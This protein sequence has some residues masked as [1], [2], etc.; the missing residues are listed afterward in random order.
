MRT[1][2]E[3]QGQKIAS[4]FLGEAKGSFLALRWP[5]PDLRSLFGVSLIF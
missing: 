2:R 5:A 4:I 1:F 3:Q